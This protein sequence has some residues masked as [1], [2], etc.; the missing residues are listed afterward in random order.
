LRKAAKRDMAER[1]LIKWMRRR[2]RVDS[3]TVP[4]GP[5]DDA[6]LVVMPSRRE[7][8]TIDTIAEGVDFVLPDTREK[9]PA[10]L[11]R[12]DPLPCPSP[13]WRGDDKGGRA[14]A[15]TRRAEFGRSDGVRPAR[16]RE[17]GRKAILVNL[18]DIAAMG[19]APSWCVVAAALR[20]GL[21]AEFAK[22][23]YL[24][25]EEAAE[26][27]GCPLVGGDVTGWNDGV[28]VT[29][30]M[31]GVL[32]GRRAITRGGARPGD[33][34][35]VTGAL[36]GSILGKHLRFE[37]RLA[38]G[39]WLA[40]HHAPTAMIDISDGL[41]VDS[42]HIG[43]E[44]GVCIEIDE[45]RI[46]VSAAAKR[47]ARRDG[48]TALHHAIADGEDFEL[49]FTVGRREAARAAKEW[50]FKTPVSEIGRVCKGRGVA[51][52]RADGARERI[53]VEG[54]EHLG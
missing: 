53:D 8:V 43:E 54:Y 44:S 48:K 38:E 4:I 32:A 31:G 3:K 17:I 11:R 12:G 13:H 20:R 28:V 33:V 10:L 1:E 50:P 16:A 34:V 22:G 29:V 6:A 19:G 5:G 52:L 41:G 42:A 30:A 47:L 40:R 14:Q 7:L 51:L 39:A 27:Y 9:G 35:C 15:L 46:P 21:G 36:G 23:L 24:G 26:E 49:L 18:S 25:L 45:A 37:P 2:I